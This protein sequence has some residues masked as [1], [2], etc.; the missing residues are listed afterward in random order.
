MKPLFKGQRFQPRWW[1]DVLAIHCVPGVTHNAKCES[2]DVKY[3]RSFLLRGSK[4]HIAPTLMHPQL[5]PVTIAQQHVHTWNTPHAKHFG[6]RPRCLGTLD[7]PSS[8]H[9]QRERNVKGARGALRHET[10]PAKM[11]SVSSKT[12]RPQKRKS[13][14]MSL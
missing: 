11:T 2:F 9:G 13:C 1:L 4:P 12:A 10:P 14:P 3:G 8:T 7:L 6:V 5:A